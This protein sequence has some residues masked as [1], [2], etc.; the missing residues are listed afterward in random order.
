MNNNPWT[1][2]AQRAQQ[3]RSRGDSRE[4]AQ[5]PGLGFFAGEAHAPKQHHQPYQLYQ[6][7]PQRQGS[8]SLTTKV[9]TM[10][11]SNLNLSDMYWSILRITQLKL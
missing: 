4:E 1:N 8:Y 3:E 7:H 11:R 9:L 6:Q 5:A 10:D 2:L